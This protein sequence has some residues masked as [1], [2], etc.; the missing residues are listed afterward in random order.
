MPAV[1]ICLRCHSKFTQSFSAQF[2]LLFIS[3]CSL[4]TCVSINPNG[5][6]EW[7]WL[8][9]GEE[10]LVQWNIWSDESS[11][12]YVNT[13]HHLASLWRWAQ[14]LAS[15]ITTFAIVGKRGTTRQKAMESSPAQQDSNDDQRLHGTHNST[16]P[17]DHVWQWKDLFIFPLLSSRRLLA[18]QQRGRWKDSGTCVHV[19]ESNLFVIAWSTIPLN[20]IFT[21]SW[22]YLFMLTSVFFQSYPFLSKR[23]NN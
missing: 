8:V 5:L 15:P 12:R 7:A 19:R 1:Q 16:T 11:R 2:M 14:G 10:K 23:K 4:G 18:D 13:K 6:C 3:T 9:A 17:V 22:F 20:S 21:C